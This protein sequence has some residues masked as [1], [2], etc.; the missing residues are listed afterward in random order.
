M[1]RQRRYLYNELRRRSKFPKYQYAYYIY[2]ILRRSSY[3]NIYTRYKISIYFTKNLFRYNSTS[4]RNRCR[5]TSRTHAVITSA[6]LARIPFRF[7]A[8]LG[9]F[10]GFTTRGK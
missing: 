7:L 6:G 1:P 8:G 3:T 9:F 2:N 10:C 4:Y 5:I